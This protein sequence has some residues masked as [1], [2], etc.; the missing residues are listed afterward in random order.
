MAVPVG[1]FAEPSDLAGLAHFL[2]H[3]LFMGS[4]KFPEESYFERLVQTEGMGN[5]NAYTSDDLTDYYFST[6]LKFK[7]TLDVFAQFFVSPLLLRSAVYRYI[8]II[9]IYLLLN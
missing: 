7:L 8:L 6:T 1:S 5:T 4:D 3:M 2:E 9:S